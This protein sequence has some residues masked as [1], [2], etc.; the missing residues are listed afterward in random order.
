MVL[1]VWEQVEFFLTSRLGIDKPLLK[2]SMS[3]D[4]YRA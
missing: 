1:N 2:S 3:R 4:K